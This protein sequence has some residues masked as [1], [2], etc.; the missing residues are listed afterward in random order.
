MGIIKIDFGPKQMD[1]TEDSIRAMVVQKPRRMKIND[2]FPDRYGVIKPYDGGGD[3]SVRFPFPETFSNAFD[4]LYKGAHIGMRTNDK[5]RCYTFLSGTCFSGEPPKEA[6]T[7]CQTIGKYVALRDCMALSFAIDYDHQG[8]DPAKPHSTVGR[9]RDLAKPRDGSVPSADNYK[10]GGKG[11]A[12]LC[13][14]FLDDLEC[15][16]NADCVVAMPSSTP[17]KQY[18][19]PRSFANIFSKKLDIDNFTKHVRTIIKRAQLKGLK[20]T[21]RL[22]EIRGTIS[23]EPGIFAGKTVILIDD[24]YQSGISINYVAMLLQQAGAKKIFGLTCDKT[25][26]N[27]DNI[28]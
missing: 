10:K 27:T 16:K 17:A 8:G 22:D 18:D 26:S 23:V 7:C 13:L 1:I 5:G 2:E 24:V 28:G 12:L 14:A 21:Q 4:S 15:Y 6:E 3:W 9:L 20:A 19:L 11:L 25:C